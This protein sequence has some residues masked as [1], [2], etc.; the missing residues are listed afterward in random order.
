[1][2]FR[3]VFAASLIILL[4][5][6]VSV[7]AGVDSINEDK[8]LGSLQE[9]GIYVPHDKPVMLPEND[10]RATIPLE[11]IEELES[12]IEP[13]SDDRKNKLHNI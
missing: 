11:L 6:G 7:W 1:M 3:T 13:K 8:V 4:L 2:K 10:N 9:Q 5:S 12:R